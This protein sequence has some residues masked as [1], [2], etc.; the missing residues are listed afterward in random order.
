MTAGDV[1]LGHILEDN[2]RAEVPMRKS[3]LTVGCLLASISSFGQ[4]SAPTWQVGLADG[5]NTGL[6]VANNSGILEFHNAVAVA[7]SIPSGDVTG[8]FHMTQRYSRAWRAANY[9][10]QFCCPEQLP[11]NGLPPSKFE[12]NLLP[13]L[14]AAVAAPFGYSKDHYIEIRWSRNGEETTTV[15]VSKGEY[16]AFLNWLTQMTGQKWIDIDEERRQ[17]LQQIDKRSD[18]AFALEAYGQ[19]FRA[20]PVDSHGQTQLYFFKG[21]VKGRNVAGI[22]PVSRDWSDNKCVNEVQVLYQH[23]GNDFC[24]IDTILF[25]EASYHVIDPQPVNIVDSGSVAANDC[26]RLDQQRKAKRD[27]T[28]TKVQRT[29]KQRD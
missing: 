8:I 16:L 12:A 7:F 27:N 5:S 23:C 20:L 26:A 22:V 9:F 4:A 13:I 25:P 24:P 11:G 17:A 19:L 1:P 2:L 28:S 18:E 21:Q 15:T 6:T 3:L 14:A 29:L 10:D